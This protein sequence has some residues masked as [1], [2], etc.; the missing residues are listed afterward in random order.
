MKKIRIPEK[1]IR[2]FITDKNNVG[3]VLEKLIVDFIGDNLIHKKKK[4]KDV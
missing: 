2:I 4:I 1:P 3:R